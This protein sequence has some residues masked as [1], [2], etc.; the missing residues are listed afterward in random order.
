MRFRFGIKYLDQYNQSEIRERLETYYKFTFVR[1]PMERLL[2]AYRSKF[3]KRKDNKQEWKEFYKAYGKM[4]SHLYGKQILEE[5]TSITFVE[6]LQYAQPQAS[7]KFYTNEHWMKQ[8][9]LCSFCGINYD[10]IGSF[11]NLHDDVAY[12]LRE[13]YDYEADYWF[14]NVT[15]PRATVNYEEKYYNQ[16]PSGLFQKV[17]NTFKLDYQLF[18]YQRRL[19]PEE[20]QL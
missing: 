10:F 13:L 1:H 14:P 12:V 8:N 17:Q 6:F 3:E 7:Q 4:F 16:V 19:F 18:D 15:R 5:N 2:S 9:M 20:E 11:D